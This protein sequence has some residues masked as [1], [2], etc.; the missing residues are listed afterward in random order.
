M[1]FEEFC[2]LTAEYGDRVTRIL[3][4][5]DVL[6][7]ADA[8]NDTTDFNAV[9]AAPLS[10]AGQEFF[11]KLVANLAGEPDETP[12]EAPDTEE[13]PETPPDTEP[14]VVTEYGDT[15]EEPDGTEAPTD[16]P[17]TEAPG[18]EA[19]KEG[20]GSAVGFAAVALLTAAAAAVMMTKKYPNGLDVNT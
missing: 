16:A 18:T 2:T 8:G 1:A 13:E 10:P 19:L 4:I 12:T 14:P 9:H 3:V 5:N 20:C 15:T 7:V 6:F 17:A 11:D